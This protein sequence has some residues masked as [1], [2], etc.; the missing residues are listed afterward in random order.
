L[1]KERTRSPVLQRVFRRNLLIAVVFFFSHSKRPSKKV[2][3]RIDSSTSWNPF[4][5]E[6]QG[7]GKKSNITQ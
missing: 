2:S 6:N 1:Y 5:R 4:P 7:T 3:I